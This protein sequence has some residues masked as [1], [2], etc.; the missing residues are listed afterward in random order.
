M[1]VENAELVT[2]RD[3]GR[4][5]AKLINRMAEGKIEKVIIMKHGKMEAVVIPVSH[6]EELTK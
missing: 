4:E 5:Y 2:A 6:Y 1:E 3:L